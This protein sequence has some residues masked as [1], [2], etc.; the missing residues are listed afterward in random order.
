MA[1]KSPLHEPREQQ[2]M[3]VTRHSTGREK[4][5][6]TKKSRQRINLD[7]DLSRR[8]KIAQTLIDLD[9]KELE[10]LIK[11]E[12]TRNEEVKKKLDA[13]KD[14]L[15]EIRMDIKEN[16]KMLSSIAEQQSEL[17]NK[18]QICTLAASRAKSE[19]GKIMA[20]QKEILM[21]MNDLRSQTHGLNRRIQ[22]YQRKRCHRNECRIIEK[23]CCF[24]EYTK[25][26][27]IIATHSFSDQMRLKSGGNWTNVYKGQINHSAVAVKMLNCVLDFSRPEFQDKV[28]NLGRIRQPHLVAVLGFCS[29][30]KCLVFEYMHRGSLEEMLFGKNRSWDLTWRDCLRIAIEVCSGL[31]F[32]NAAQPRPIAHCAPSP[33]KILLDCNLVAKITGFGLQGC[34]EQ[35]NHE[36]EMKAIGVLLQSLLTGRRNWV[37]MD[38]ESEALYDEIGEQ[39]PLDVAREVVGLAM[40]CMS[41]ESEPNGEMSITRVM[42]ELNEIIRKGDEMVAR[43]RWNSDSTHVPSVFVC[44]ILQ[45]IMKNPYI[46]A[47]G[48]SYELEAIEEWLQ[49]GNDISPKN[50]RLDHK[51]LTPNHTL[52]SLIEDWQTKTS[53]TLAN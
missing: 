11:E 29:E 13:E 1:P 16:K 22:F 32:L 8:T 27:I 18:L 48:Y 34:I 41:I 21:E 5:I 47:D 17:Q 30:P 35:C 23:G 39:W 9:E 3:F 14:Q 7:E 50:L 42:G 53:A 2:Q 19:V 24:R 10:P 52:R 31:G 44:P 38:T 36:S 49:S 51:L 40:R 20:E 43:E 28:E 46:A 33:S 4:L 12:V 15:N 25:E 6:Q 45:K 37:T 26:E